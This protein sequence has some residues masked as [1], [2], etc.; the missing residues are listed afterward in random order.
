MRL[1]CLPVRPEIV[2]LVPYDISTA[3]CPSPLLSGF[4]YVAPCLAAPE[5]A[6]LLTPP[7]RHRHEQNHEHD[8]DRNNDHDDTGANGEHEGSV[9]MRLLPATIARPHHTP[10][11]SLDAS[12]S[13]IRRRRLSGCGA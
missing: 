4:L 13:F 10:R 5:R 12:D 7:H 11:L 8:G 9:H 3:L 2:S 1:P 6:A